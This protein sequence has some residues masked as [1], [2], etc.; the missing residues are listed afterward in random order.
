MKHLLVCA[1]AG[2]LVYACPAA[3][4][5]PV[6]ASFS[7]WFDNAP[8]PKESLDETA[9]AFPSMNGT[10]SSF[11]ASYQIIHQPMTSLRA[12]FHERFREGL[13]QPASAFSADE[14]QLLDRYRR[15]QQGL[16][17]EGRL[18]LFTLLF[19]DRP[20]LASQK[21]SWSRPGGLSAAASAQ[22]R[23]L[24]DIERSLNWPAFHSDMLKDG[25]LALLSRRDEELETLNRT[26]AR[27][28]A[29][30]PLKLVKAMAGSDATVEMSDPGAMLPLLNEQRRQ[31][32][33]HLLKAYRQRYAWYR[34]RFNRVQSAALRLDSLLQATA[35]GTALEGADV[36]LRP[37]LADLQLRVWEMTHYLHAI[38]TD[39]IQRARIKV[40]AEN[41]SD[42]AIRLYEKLARG[43][44]VAP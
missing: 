36:S 32:S 4:Q 19:E 20:L 29:E 21:L 16:G 1:L 8:L 5:Q 2:C 28:Q 42:E 12:R 24:L 22:L 6:A 9:A 25:P 34:E 31:L 30:V 15:G 44:G 7:S 41:Q 33:A 23:S 13:G 38:G 35:Y 18:A 39:L 43:E 11:D 14:R 40:A 17:A 37:L 26:F 27:K 10:E 3:A